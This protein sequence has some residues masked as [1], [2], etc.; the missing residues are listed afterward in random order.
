MAAQNSGSLPGK[1]EILLNNHKG[2]YSIIAE[3]VEERQILIEK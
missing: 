3:F 1:G 2:F